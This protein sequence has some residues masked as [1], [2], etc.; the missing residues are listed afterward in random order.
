ME[1]TIAYHKS[2]DVGEWEGGI[3]VYVA[4]GEHG[5]KVVSIPRLG[6][7][8]ALI[9]LNHVDGISN[10]LMKNRT[11]Y[12]NPEEMDHFAKLIMRDIQRI[13]LPDPICTTKK[14]GRPVTQMEAIE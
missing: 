4:R 1:Q 12:N 10:M 11:M 2:Y 6:L 9:G 5:V 3:A 13:S 7:S 14:R 8:T